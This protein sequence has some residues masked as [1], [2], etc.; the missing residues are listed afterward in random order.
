MSQTTKPHQARTPAP[1]EQTECSLPTLPSGPEPSPCKY[2][3]SYL[4]SD[5]AD[6]LKIYVFCHI[7]LKILGGKNK[8]KN[9]LQRRGLFHTRICNCAKCV[10]FFSLSTLKQ[11]LGTCITLL[12]PLITSDN[13]TLTDFEVTVVRREFIRVEGNAAENCAKASPSGTAD[14]LLLESHW[15]VIAEDTATGFT[16]SL[17]AMLAVKSDRPG[18]QPQLRTSQLHKLGQRVEL[19]VPRFSLLFSWNNPACLIEL[20]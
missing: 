11:Y 19:D 16:G 3:T 2:P 13:I 1:S 20:L 6:S 14:C 12:L 4:F 7:S 18:S 8:N 5:P 17:F 9:K 15:E 10:C